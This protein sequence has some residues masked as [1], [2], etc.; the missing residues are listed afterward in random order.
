MKTCS[1]WNH[2]SLR[3]TKCLCS[4]YD[5]QS[6]PKPPLGSFPDW[7]ARRAASEWPWHR[8]DCWLHTVGV[9]GVQLPMGPRVFGCWAAGS[10]TAGTPNLNPNCLALSGLLI[11]L[12][13]TTLS[14]S[15]ACPGRR[16][17]HQWM[18]SLPVN[19]DPS[20]EWWQ[21]M[22]TVS[23]PANP[24]PLSSPFLQ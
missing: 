23:S 4:M 12:L 9:E 16:E 22:R 6:S 7:P 1:Q 13:P 2:G 19:T 5:K 14:V 8:W 18:R 10:H 20:V 11:T 15:H 21:K 3:G 17:P 24:G